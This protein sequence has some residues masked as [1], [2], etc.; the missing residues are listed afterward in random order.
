MPSSGSLA[1]IKF[2]EL[3]DAFHFVSFGDP[4]EHRAF[5]NPD[6]ETIF[7]L[8]EGFDTEDDV[9]GDFETS[10]QYI[11]V[12]HKHDLDLGRQLV[13]SFAEE[14][15]PDHYNV[16]A[17]FF[18]KKGAYRRFKDFLEDRGLV[19]QWYAYEAQVIEIAL[20]AWAEEARIEFLPEQTP[21]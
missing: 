11:A 6:T 18:R 3:L 14:H 10:D 7:Y 9:P 12:P 21:T 8:S 19:E 20:R 13:L 15:M 5:I 4:F 17:G 16:V 1:K 2:S